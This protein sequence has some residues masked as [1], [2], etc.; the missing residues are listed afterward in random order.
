MRTHAQSAILGRFINT[1]PQLRDL[2]VIDGSR[3]GPG[4]SEKDA[5][6]RKVRQV[7]ERRP[8]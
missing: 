7:I 4:D 5:G 2:W 6:D 8:N 3:K 1:L